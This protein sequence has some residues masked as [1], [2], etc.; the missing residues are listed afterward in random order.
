MRSISPTI[1]SSALIQ[2]ARLARAP[3][4]GRYDFSY[5]AQVKDLLCQTRDMVKFIAHSVSATP[6]MK[7]EVKAINAEADRANDEILHV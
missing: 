6:E 1:S 5:I 7:A 2:G 3:G 4:A